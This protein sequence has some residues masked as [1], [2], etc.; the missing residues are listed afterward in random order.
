M[1]PS[2]VN[3]ANAGGAAMV[4]CEGNCRLRARAES[5]GFFKPGRPDVIYRF[6]RNREYS[7]RK[8]RLI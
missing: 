2:S 8:G 4:R 7:H 1:M 5:Y 3:G 6:G